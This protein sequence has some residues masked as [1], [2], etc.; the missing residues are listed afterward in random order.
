MRI[1]IVSVGPKLTVK[2]FGEPISMKEYEA[3]FLSNVEGEPRAAVKRLT[4][5]IEADLTR[6]TINAPDWYVNHL[7]FYVR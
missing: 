2:S 1:P 5:R 3:Q 6:A 7:A 4:Q